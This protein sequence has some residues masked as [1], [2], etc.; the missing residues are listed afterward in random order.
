MLASI[1]MWASPSA[2]AGLYARASRATS[3]YAAE[4]S[5]VTATA[6]PCIAFAVGSPPSA[7]SIARVR[8]ESAARKPLN[9]RSRFA[10]S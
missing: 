9:A 5:P 6:P 10:S 8:T 1:A 2:C 7:A 4:N 3:Q